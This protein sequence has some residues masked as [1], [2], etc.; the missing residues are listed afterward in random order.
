MMSTELIGWLLRS[1]IALSLGVLL[2]LALR[3]L[4][5]RL[6]GAQVVYAAWLMLPVLMLAS[7]L[8]PLL[9]EAARELAWTPPVVVGVAAAAATS[10]VAADDGLPLMLHAWWLGMLVLVMLHGRR[11]RRFVRLLG[12]LSPRGDGS[13]I[14]AH[15]GLGP[16][17]LGLWRPR[18]VLP[19]DFEQRY[20]PD[21]R[22]LVLAHENVHLRRGDLWI[23]A[24]I[25][26]LQCVHWFNPLVHIAASRLRRDQELA[27]DATVI[28]S[29]P[30]SRRRYADAMLNS[31][32]AVPGLPVGCLWQSSHPLKERILMLKQSTPSRLRLALGTGLA[33]AISTAGGLAVATAGAGQIKSTD[34]TLAPAVDRD[35]SYRQL[36]PP[37]YPAEALAAQQSGNVVLRVLVGADGKPLQVEVERSSEVAS[38]DA[39]AIESVEHW[40]FNPGMRAGQPVE[41]WVLV[42]ISFRHDE[43]VEAEPAPEGALDTIWLRPSAEG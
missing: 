13:Y 11:Q 17:V 9:P 41:G 2:V 30:E 42:P 6:F 29:H 27:C 19:A 36:A 40:Q 26:A 14:A 7:L 18:I 5:M 32:L 21:Q 25:T 20:A 34:A 3:P 23:N 10:E 33:L 24:A 35:Q 8:P 15:A 38:L 22:A 4:L 43:S 1:S 16:A 12:P 39:A 31:Q 37:K 28:A